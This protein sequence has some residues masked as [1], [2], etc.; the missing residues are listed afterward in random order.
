MPEHKP[1]FRKK[2]LSCVF[3]Q[4]LQR[5]VEDSFLCV[6][7]DDWPPCEDFGYCW[8]LEQVHGVPKPHVPAEPKR[9]FVSEAA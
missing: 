8:A 6:G 5:S 7:D 2:G 1:K 4:K 9:P 3:Y